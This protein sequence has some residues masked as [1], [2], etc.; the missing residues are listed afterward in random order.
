MPSEREITAWH[1]SGHAVVGVH[2]GLRVRHVRIDPPRGLTTF[3]QDVCFARLAPRQHCLI[4]MAGEV[5]EK[6]IL[7]CALIPDLSRVR[8]TLQ[9]LR[10]N[11]SLPRGDIANIVRA[12]AAE[13]CDDQLAQELLS[14]VRAIR[15]L[16][17]HDDL[18][19]RVAA[20]AVALID[21]GELSGFEVE[22]LV[23]DVDQ[24]RSPIFRFVT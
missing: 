14:R 5:A 20:V 24:Q 2:F 23:G 18:W 4:S 17:D 7:G 22:A 13:Q 19:T 6:R 12:L 21:R 9:S 16:L 11:E 10:R 8:D 15:R 1:E 3:W